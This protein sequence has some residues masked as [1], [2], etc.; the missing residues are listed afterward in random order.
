MLKLKQK[1]SSRRTKQPSPSTG[2]STDSSA[3]SGPNSP[4]GTPS[5]V[6][7]H[8]TIYQLPVS[9]WFDLSVSEDLKHLIISGEPTVLELQ[10]AFEHMINEF[11]TIMQS[12]KTDAIVRITKR[13]GLLQ[14]QIIYVDNTLTYLTEKHKLDGGTNK[15]LTTELRKLG[16]DYKFDPTNKYQY[17]REL[18]FVRS[19]AKSLITQRRDL[20]KE[21][22]R[23][24]AGK[25]GNK[26]KS[27]AD[28]ESEL[29]TLGRYQ[30]Y[31]I[32]PL[33]TM[34]SKYAVMLN[35]YNQAQVAAKKVTN[36][37]R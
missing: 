11:S 37:R 16:Y 12:D 22:H 18:G 6:T 13:I 32:N 1:N 36:G 20:L 7:F 30:G 4:A 34:T 17:H 19:R 10:D 5:S 27:R 35:Q 21:Y 15:D 28:Y 24:T 25:T 9:L 31:D 26:K 8:T 23:M 14:W 2:T 3:T 33:T 29:V